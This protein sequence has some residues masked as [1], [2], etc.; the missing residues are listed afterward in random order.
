MTNKKKL[1]PAKDWRNRDI[2][3]WNVATFHAYLAHLNKEKYGID[4]EPFGKGPVS[5]RWRTEQGQ[6]KNSINQ[7]GQPTVKRFIDIAFH[8]R[9]FNPKYPV[10]SYGFM[11]SYMRTEL[12]QAQADEVRKQKY[13]E[14][15]ECSDL[16]EIDVEWF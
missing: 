12:S 3:D 7:Y 9:P 6:L 8:N 13:E 16:G 15:I 5:N 4:Y 10:L 1:A 11:F 14:E 2:D